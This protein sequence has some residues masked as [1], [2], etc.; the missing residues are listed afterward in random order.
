MGV[1]GEPPR[2]RSVG[3]GNGNLRLIFQGLVCMSLALTD[4][5]LRHAYSTFGA[6]FLRVSRGRTG[7]ASASC[8]C[9]F[10]LRR[11]GVPSFGFSQAAAVFAPPP[12]LTRSDFP[13]TDST[14]RRPH[15][16][17]ADLC[18]RRQAIVR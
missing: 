12:P 11:G 8:V 6:A 10:G 7:T 5:C 2:C 13:Y 4:D 1:R 16:S 3:S 9:A 15:T 14:G 17:H 18:A